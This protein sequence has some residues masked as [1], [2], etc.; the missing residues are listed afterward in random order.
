MQ[1]INT[2]D[3]ERESQQ[4]FMSD[5]EEPMRP[6]GREK[7]RED[8][9]LIYTTCIRYSENLMMNQRFLR[10][11]TSER[12]RNIFEKLTLTNILEDVNL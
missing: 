10:P 7:M 6:R 3:Y 2:V 4:V 11:T 9:D 12:K 1:S 5:E 8:L